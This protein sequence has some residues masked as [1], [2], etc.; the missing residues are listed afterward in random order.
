[1]EEFLTSWNTE[2]VVN[3]TKIDYDHTTIAYENLIT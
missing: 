2:V 1:M 3:F